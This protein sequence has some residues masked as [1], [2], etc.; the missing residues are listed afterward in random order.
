MKL[1]RAAVIVAAALF[2]ASCTEKSAPERATDTK[3]APPVSDAARKAEPESAQGEEELQPREDDI[4]EDCVAFVRATKA[5]PAPAGNGDC[6]TCLAAGAEV[7]RFRAMKT[8]RIS[9]ANDACDVDVT[10]LASFNPNGSGDTITGGLTAWIPPEQ[11]QEYLSGRA[12]D[13][14]RAYRVKITYK[15]RGET[16]RAVEFVPADAE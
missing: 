11:R 6:P 16:W 12:P 15:L 2:A 10:I 7:L 9:C 3:P 5:L 13:E 14:E 1:S 4:G 8:D